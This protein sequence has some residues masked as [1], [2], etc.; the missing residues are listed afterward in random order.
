MSTSEDKSKNEVTPPQPLTRR[1][2]RQMRETGAIPVVTAEVIAAVSEPLIEEQPGTKAAPELP[3]PIEL[4]VVETESAV[5]DSTAAE[6][7]PEASELKVSDDLGAQLVLDEADQ[8]EVSAK[9]DDLISADETVEEVD[10]TAPGNLTTPLVANVDSTGEVV[11]TG[12]FIL[13]T[14]ETKT[15]LVETNTGATAIE[16]L[17]EDKEIPAHSSPTPI[18]ASSA[19]STIRPASDVIKPP[20]PDKGSRMM[21]I[22]SLTAGVLGLALVGVFIYAFATGVFR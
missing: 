2:L 12:S 7:S 11:F 16:E 17:L 9:F 8:A 21:L 22:L 19:I 1:Q 5:S 15:K 3:T 13:P 4:E 6:V 10:L 20:A 14:A 18:A